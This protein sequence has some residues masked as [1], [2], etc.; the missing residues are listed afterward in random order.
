MHHGLLHRFRDHRSVRLQ[1]DRASPAK[2]GQYEQIESAIKPCA[3]TD[4]KVA[5]AFP[6]PPKREQRE[7]GRPADRV[8]RA[9]VIIVA[10]ATV[11]VSVF[12]FAGS[13]GVE[14]PGWPLVLP[15]ARI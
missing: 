9:I 11:P 2:A 14:L 3:T 1:A 5:Q 6:G 10:V 12:T 15:L 13:L 8:H 4:Q 7:G